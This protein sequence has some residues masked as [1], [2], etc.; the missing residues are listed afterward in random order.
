MLQLEELLPE[1]HF[2]QPPARFTDASLIKMVFRQRILNAVR[3]ACH[4]RR[5]DCFM[6][7]LRPALGFI[8]HTRPRGLQMLR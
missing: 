5:A 6:G 7:V 2:T 8:D 1:Q 4:V 3:R